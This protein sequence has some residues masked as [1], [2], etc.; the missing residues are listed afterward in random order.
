MRIKKES[1]VLP[2]PSD[3]LLANEER[4]W[5]I[6]LPNSYK[7]LLKN[8]NGGVPI[9]SSFTC[10]NHSYA[11]DRFLCV[12]EDT[13]NSLLGMYDIDVI[14]TQIGER[15]ASDGDLLGVELLPIAVLFA[16]DFL[17]LDYSKSR[18]NPAV[19]VWN[20]EESGELDPVTYL[21][22]NNF[23]DFLNMLTE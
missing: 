20:H 23:E 13:E 19:C 17:C 1:V 9:E 14:L 8:S 6:H 3:E 12:L 21:T 10:N 2:L 15:L 22:A 7:E 16:G 11:V 5:R 4:M 18:L